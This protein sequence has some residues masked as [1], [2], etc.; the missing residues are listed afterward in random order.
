MHKAPL[1]PFLP[2]NAIKVVPSLYRHHHP[3][4]PPTLDF[5]PATASAASAC[6]LKDVAQEQ[7]TQAE[8][9]R[10]AGMSREKYPPAHPVKGAPAA[11]S[12][13][14]PGATVESRVVGWAV[15]GP[16]TASA[17]ATAKT[18]AKP[19]GE[20]VGSGSGSGSGSGAL[21]MEEDDPDL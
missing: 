7:Y 1:P 13:P 6:R 4:F 11:S 17:A 20:V 16:E 3:T 21:S 14:A 9:E 15:G 2:S 12:A 19:A 18:T 5:T 10:A 8:A